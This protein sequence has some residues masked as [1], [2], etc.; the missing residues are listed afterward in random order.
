MNNS[1]KLAILS[2]SI[3]TLSAC[4][5]SASEKVFEVMPEGLA[6]CRVYKIS[7]SSGV[8]LMAMRCPNS[9]TSTTYR[10]SK[11]TKTTVVVDK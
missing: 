7:N 9:G 4:T 3:A 5:P 2:L 6:D 1:I 11:T 8:E 10:E